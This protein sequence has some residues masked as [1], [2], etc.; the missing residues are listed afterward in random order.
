MRNYSREK[1]IETAEKALKTPGT[2]YKQRFVNYTGDAK[3]D[4]TLYS[5]IVSEE[6]LKKIEAF[7]SS[8]L[9]IERQKSYKQES[10]N[11]PSPRNEDSNRKEE[12]IAF[13]MRGDEHESIGKIIDYQI[14][15]KNN[16]NDKG[17][18]KIDLF[19]Y[20]ENKKTITLLEL[21]KP[22]STETLLRCVLEIFTYYK[23]LYKENFVDDYSKELNITEHD[24][25]EVLNNI[26]KAV[27][28]FT[29]SRAYRDY[30]N[31]NSFVR[32]LMKEL[33]V[34]I[35]VAKKANYIIEKIK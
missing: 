14:P 31:E 21:K 25:S 13:D 1:I 32:K 22:G 6:I 35:Y 34:D 19:S 2:L 3:N 24:K 11:T 5:E 30:Q 20:D 16:N 4:G 18:G 9:E 29:D 8:I 27:L 10:H 12:R 26:K 17:V 7:K 33:E 23:Q 15:L 28:I